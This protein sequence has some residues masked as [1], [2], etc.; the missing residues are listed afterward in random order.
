[1]SDHARG[2]DKEQIETLH[3]LARAGA[4][5]RVP[6]FANT[7]PLA[8][9]YAQ[10]FSAGTRAKHVEII[11]WGWN[12]VEEV[13]REQ[14]DSLAVYYLTPADR[15]RFYSHIQPNRTDLNLEYLPITVYQ[16]RWV[17]VKRS[18]RL[19]KQ[20]A[21]FPDDDRPY[22]RSVIAT[23][24]KDSDR[25]EIFSDTPD[26]AWALAKLLEVPF[27]RKVDVVDVHGDNALDRPPR[28]NHPL[29]LFYFSA[30]GA[31]VL[32]NDP[33]FIS[34]RLDDDLAAYDA[35]AAFETGIAFV[36]S[37][38]ADG[39]SIP[40]LRESLSQYHVTLYERC[41]DRHADTR[42]EHFLELTWVYNRLARAQRITD[43]FESEHDFA[44]CI[45]DHHAA[46]EPV[47]GASST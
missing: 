27:A 47:R 16:P 38:D 37:G 43:T 5:V 3:P 2:F 35:P 39:H 45:R 41:S 32:L 36:Y 7:L 21:P 10:W 15:G 1:M 40:A 31:S 6:M 24:V 17:F 42:R 44:T 34:L 14:T 4:V 29:Q 8:Y 28:P 46:P 20:I 22:L 30:P 12:A 13:I 25:C 23:L 19:H 33:R 11:P 9:H 26:Q 18:L